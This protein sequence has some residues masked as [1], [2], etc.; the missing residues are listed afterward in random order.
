MPLPALDDVEGMRVPDDLP[1]LVDAHVHVFPDRVFEAVWRWFDRYGW[2]VRYKLY[3]DQVISTLRARGV[4]HQVL[5]HYAHKPG[6]ARAM[7]AFVAELVTRHD[8]VTG[9]ATV[10]PG[11]PD[12][13]QILADAF[14]AGLRGVK[15]HCHVQ[16]MPAD[17]RALWPVY[18]MC[19]E[20]ELPVVIHA[21]REPH[22]DNLPVDPH[23]ICAVDRVA[24][25]LT[26]FPRLKLC[27]PHLGADEFA[28]YAA[29]MVRHD[30]LWLD[31]TMMLADFFAIE[32]PTPHIVARPE[33]VLFGTDFPNLPYAW[34]R[35]AVRLAR[36]PLTDRTLEQVCATSARELFNIRA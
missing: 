29:L 28:A 13:E 11:E 25:V 8:D 21:G 1:P 26:E 17:S 6:M 18:A 7:N 3:A 4:T 15:L 5:L 36:K 31:T 9:L 24:R 2:P 19:Q 14:D 27:V 32:D 35:E 34:D 30:N 16:G 12:Q 10:F 20:R 23:T 22:S 33:R